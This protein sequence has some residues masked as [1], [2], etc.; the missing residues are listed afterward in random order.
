MEIHGAKFKA[1][2]ISVQ[3]RLFTLTKAKKYISEISCNKNIKMGNWAT[4]YCET[5]ARRWPHIPE[6]E[7]TLFCLSNKKV[8]LSYQH[9]F[10]VESESGCIFSTISSL[11]LFTFH[12]S[13]HSGEEP[14]FGSL[15][16]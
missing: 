3:F 15:P 11:S 6:L 2:N 14:I 7:D 5:P 12:F 4:S 9:L 10:T 13:T 1:R 8:F 16:L